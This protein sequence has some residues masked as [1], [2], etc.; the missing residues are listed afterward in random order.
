MIDKNIFVKGAITD[1]DNMFRTSDQWDF[2]TLNARIMNRK[3][4]GLVITNM[5]GNKEEFEINTGYVVIGA[6][7]HNGILYIVSH[8]IEESFTP[9]RSEIGCFPSPKEW[10]STNT[11]F[12]RTY[13]ALNNFYIPTTNKIFPLRTQLFNFT[14]NTVLDIFADESYDES[15]NLYLTDYNNPV[16][17]INTNFNK[18]G[19]SLERYISPKSFNGAI[20]LIAS[21]AEVLDIE[22]LGLT[23]TGANK[24]GNYY[25]FF[26]YLT[27]DFNGT[28]FVDS[29]GPICV[30]N[31]EK[32]VGNKA[33]MQEKD[34]IIDSEN[35][36]NK[37]IKI[38]LKNLDKSFTYVQVGVVRN[39]SLIENAKADKDTY[40]IDQKFAINDD[41]LEINIT[42]REPQAVLAYEEILKTRIPF[43]INKSHCIVN[44]IYYGINWKK[45]ITGDNYEL[46]RQAALKVKLDFNCSIGNIC[47][48]GATHKRIDEYNQIKL[49][50]SFYKKEENV[51]KYVGYAR[52]EIYPYSMKYIFKNGVESDWFPVKGNI[53]G[54]E[55]DKGLYKFPFWNNEDVQTFNYALAIMFKCDLFKQYIFDNPELFK[56][57]IAI[58]FGRSQRIDNMIC[59][60]IVLTGYKSAFRTVDGIANRIDFTNEKSGGFSNI[61]QN[62]IVPLW[63]GCMPIAAKQASNNTGQIVY[64]GAISHTYKNEFLI[65]SGTWNLPNF[66]TVPSNYSGGSLHAGLFSSDI[67]LSPYVYIPD[68]VYLKHVYTAHAREVINSNHPDLGTIRPHIIGVEA[69]VSVAKEKLSFSDE[70]RKEDNVTSAFIEKSTEMGALN[71]T[72]KMKPFM[73]AD[74]H[75]NN[76][77]RF[78]NRGFQLSRY[79]G[80]NPHTI[81]AFSSERYTGSNYNQKNFIDVYNIYKT[82]PDDEDYLK[83]VVNDFLPEVTIYDEISKLVSI[84]N[85]DDN[86]I[87][88]KGDTF[89]Q[90]SFYRTH[91]WYDFEGANA[92]GDSADKIKGGGE[93]WQYMGYQSNDHDNPFYQWGFLLGMLT[94]NFINADARNEISLYDDEQEKIKYSYWPKVFHRATF[95]QWVVLGIYSENA[96]EATQINDG[97]NVTLP[98]KVGIGY[99]PKIPQESQDQRKTRIYHSFKKAEG[100]IIDAYRDIGINNYIDLP[101]ENG[102]GMRIIPYEKIDS[103]LSIQKESINQHYIKERVV[104]SDGSSGN[105]ILVPEISIL[106]EYFKNLAKYGTQHMMSVVKA[107]DIVIGVD[108]KNNVIWMVKSERNQSGNLYLNSINLIKTKYI[109]KWWDE[110]KNRLSIYSDITNELPNNIIDGCGIHSVYNEKFDEIYI[111]FIIPTSTDDLSRTPGPGFSQIMT[112]S[113]TLVYH[114]DFDI[115]VGLTSISSYKFMNLN[116]DLYSLGTGDK[117][118]VVYFHDVDDKPQSFYDVNYPFIL[119]FIVTGNS[120]ES[121]KL[122]DLEKTFEALNIE[123][124]KELLTSILY[125]TESQKSIYEFQSKDNPT[126][127]FWLY[128]EY[129]QNEWQIPIFVTTEDKGKDYHLDSLIR[130]RWLK[131]TLR[132]F[133][134]DNI[135]DIYIKRVLTHFNIIKI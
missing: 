4:Q 78:Y 37:S 18:K 112:N 21:S 54:V 3:G 50:N 42:G 119:T 94:E 1:L 61:N 76:W 93:G 19:N 49:D 38:K 90:R 26:K 87:I 56:D 43:N 30:L 103:F 55:N 2:P 51:Y 70:N 125:E 16:R 68:S 89:L 129:L 12:E 36:T 124:T 27:K 44:N 10:T 99:D 6:C 8:N 109:T 69:D 17:V 66:L 28:P 72:S 100:S 5:A 67:I 11:V 32:P 83:S 57:V 116:K 86:I 106:P 53:N 20:N 122:Y 104:E 135:K 73:W 77:I 39:T 134:S 88:F 52:G 128:S 114:V 34:W 31:Q 62:K 133:P 7:Q 63:K 102:D 97:Y 121:E 9:G 15:V 79:I 95:K 60:G 117:K 13:K 105:I 120:S 40:V 91:R 29:I 59:Q 101:S 126:G 115:I 107:E 64:Y 41:E 65:G 23:N 80:L 46:L 132:Y 98:G 130:G 92:M 45:D 131:V 82:N 113:F 24:P 111:N 96:V 84:D 110:L 71:F 58:K 22:F 123:M 33:G 48:D 108:W 47:T 85:I 75:G 35:V 118:N 74:L 81:L 14:K 25:L 127:K